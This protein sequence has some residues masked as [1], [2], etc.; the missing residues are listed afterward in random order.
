V[1]TVPTSPDGITKT[2]I[3]PIKYVVIVP[4][5]INSGQNKR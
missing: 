1:R 3:P 4:A 5:R 2:C